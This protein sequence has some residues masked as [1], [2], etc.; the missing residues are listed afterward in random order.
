MWLRRLGADLHRDSAEAAATEISRG[1]PG[2]PRKPAPGKATPAPVAHRITDEAIHSI[3]YD[4][5]LEIPVDIEPSPRQAL[6]CAPVL[7]R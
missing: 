3:T 4:S 6:P 5:T 7:E 2:C 1:I